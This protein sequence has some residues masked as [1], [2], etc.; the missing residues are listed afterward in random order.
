[1]DVIALSEAGF[2]ASVAPLG[3]AV[4]DTQIQLMWRLSPEP[5]IALDG[6]KAGLRAAFRVIDLALPLLEAGKGLRFALMPE[7]KDPD[8]L[9][10]A[11]GPEAVQKVL[12]T[13]IPMV[14]LLWRQETEG[15]VFDSPERRAALD[16]ALRSR[17][18]KIQDPSL[19]HHY[20]EALKEL[21]YQ[22]YRPQRP[23]RAPQGK[24]RPRDLPAPASPGAKAS[25]LVAA[26]GSWER[27]LREQVILAVLL[28][29]P[30]VVE[31]FES[32]LDA[33][34]CSD[35]QLGALR[36][37]ILHSIGNEDEMKS[38]AAAAIG[39]EAL[40][41]LLSERHVAVVPCIRVPGDAELARMTVSEELA[42][43]SAYEGW[44][45]ELKEGQEDITDLADEVVTRRLAE[46]ARVRAQAGRRRDEDDTQY[47]I[48]PNGA[49]VS[50]EELAARDSLF[51]TI[52]FEKSRK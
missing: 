43:L 15:R 18:A 4:T 28:S 23:Q 26:G 19:R 38:R 12:E 17:I 52:R 25:M 10:R 42:K 40:E 29:A 8:D 37:A 5:I 16:K 33:M 9:L 48:A 20:G 45:A 47:D 2:H 30:E 35:P 41:N 50:K 34:I 1:M 13:A 22:F 11:E 36:D 44:H 14:H 3:T 7:G 27:R 6:D 51:A 32:Q 49:Q 31:G 24:F 39:S 46:A 21:R